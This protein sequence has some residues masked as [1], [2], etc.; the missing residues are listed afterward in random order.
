MEWNSFGEYNPVN[1]TECTKECGLCLK[2]CPFTDY[3]ENEDLV[4]DRF[5]GS[6]PGIMH[7]SE[8]GY[9]L[10]SYVGYSMTHRLTSASGGIATWILENLLTTA[11]VDQVICVAPNEDPEKLFAFKIFHTME[12]VREGAGSAYYPVEMSEVIRHILSTPGRYAITG[13]PCFIKAIRNAQQNNKKLMERIVVTVGLTCGQMKSKH[14]TAYLTALSGADGTVLKVYYRGKDSNKPANNFY[15]SCIEKSGAEKVIF[16]NEGVEEAWLNRWFTPRACTYCDDV[17][18]ECADITFM[19][20]W[21]STYSQDYRGTNLVLVREPQIKDI[22]EE[23]CKSLQ[24]SLTS[25]SIQKIIES[26]AEVIKMKR[27]DLA[28]RLHMAHQNR[29]YIPKKRVTITKVSNPLKK[30]EISNLDM[31]QTYSKNR[32]LTYS[33]K[34][35]RFDIKRFREDLLPYVRK[36]TVVKS[37]SVIVTESKCNIRRLIKRLRDHE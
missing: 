11:I 8:A 17:F 28:L 26:Q 20:A 3:G 25:I 27:E 13:L 19:D 6:V 5:Y 37:F 18:A 15:F 33:L 29:H 31:M 36:L 4:G 7:T 10:A 24:I 16:W 21:L 35:G 9:Y 1:K 12:E 22:L 34:G 2:V 14:Y 30:I 32:Y 23:G